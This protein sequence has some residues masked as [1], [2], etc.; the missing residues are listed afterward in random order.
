MYKEIAEMTDSELNELEQL[1]TAEKNKRD[2]KEAEEALKEMRA[3]ID[4]WAEK[5]IGFYV[6]DSYDCRVTIYPSEVCVERGWI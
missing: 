3:L 5:H 2:K 6:Y 4:K 1:I